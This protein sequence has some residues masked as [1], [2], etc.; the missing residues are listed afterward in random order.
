MMIMIINVN[1]NIYIYVFIYIYIDAT[2]QDDEQVVPSRK[3]DPYCPFG[4]IVFIIIIIIMISVSC[5]KLRKT[6]H[7]V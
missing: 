6:N 5:Y 3:T 4:T 1:T 7:T 2:F